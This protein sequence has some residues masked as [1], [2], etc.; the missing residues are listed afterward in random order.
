MKHIKLY[1]QFIL[2]SKEEKEAKAILQD[3]LDEH[4]PWDLMDMLP[5]EA[6]D[7]V[8]AYGHKGAS[9]K[10]IADILQNLASK[11]I[12][13]GKTFKVGDKWEWHTSD[14]IKVVSITNV[15]SNGDV[16]GRED[17]S[18]EDFIVREPSKYLKKK[19]NESVINEDVSTTFLVLMQ[20]AI[21][22][23]MLIGQLAANSGGDGFHP[24]DD[25]KAWWQK[26]K[27]DKALKSI[28]DKIKDDEDVVKFMKLT[29]SQ[30]RG[31]FRSLIATKLNDDEL[32]Y[33]N[34]IN[35]SHFQ[36]ESVINEA[37]ILS[38]DEMKNVMITKY[39]LSFVKTT[40]EFDGE[41]GGIWLGG[42]DGKLMP[43]AK[44]DMFNYYHGGSKYPQG[45]H[46]DLAK[47]L[48][49]CGWYG[50]FYDAGTVMLW[51]K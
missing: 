6:L 46:K 35:R 8:A 14:G 3:L 45:I 17:G 23:G 9:A 28:V 20:A 49:K 31:K 7:T 2:E 22:N 13:E 5:G 36:T 50:Q 34:K 19:V 38:R 21:V 32:E 26:R 33:L 44:D 41:E 51:P 16:I 15:K 37:K 47:F 40:E 27:S 43:N 29:P 39:G 24:I 42:S 12:F 10:K 48:D 18:S 11:G 1:E 25:L 4:D 30:Q